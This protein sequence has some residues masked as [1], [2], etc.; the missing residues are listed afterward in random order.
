VASCHSLGAGKNMRDV[1]V[2]DSTCIESS[3]RSTTRLGMHASIGNIP[4][5]AAVPHIDIVIAQKKIGFYVVLI[6]QSFELHNLTMM[7][8]A[9]CVVGHVP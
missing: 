7:T 5:H 4:R 3:H 6:E 2:S 1:G 8:R 9:S